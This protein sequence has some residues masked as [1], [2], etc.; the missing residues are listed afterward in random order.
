MEDM[1]DVEVEEWKVIPEF[2]NYEVSNLGRVKSLQYKNNERI[3]KQSSLPRGYLAFHLA[4]NGIRKYYL[5][6][7]LVLH[8]FDPRENEG[9]LIARHLN[10]NTSDNRL[11]NLT[12]GTH[13][14]NMEDLAKSGKRKGVLNFQSRLTEQQVIDIF[15]NKKSCR[16][17]AKEYK[18]SRTV[19][20][21][22]KNKKAWEHLFESREPIVLNY[23]V[24]TSVKRCLENNGVFI[25]QQPYIGTTN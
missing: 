22:I 4:N 21:N 10:D 20:S 3:M 12:W 2:P 24:L 18:I 14:D 1:N 25:I 19:V 8:V 5:A 17:I 13:K 6:H 11:S 15:N 16:K 7:R 23:R 9:E